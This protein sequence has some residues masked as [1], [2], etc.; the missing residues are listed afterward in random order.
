MAGALGILTLP[1]TAPSSPSADACVG[2]PLRQ[3]L[4]EFLQAAIRANCQAAWAGIAGVNSNVVERIEVNDPKDNTFVASKLPCLAIFRTERQRKFEQMGDDV[5][6]RRSKI[7]VLWIPPVAVQWHRA[8]REP[9]FQAV[10][11]AIDEAVVRGRTPTWVDTGD[12]ETRAA[13]EGSLIDSRLELLYPLA[14]D[15]QFDDFS[16]EITMPGA[17]P[18]K[19]P[20]LM[21]T[22]GIVE[23]GQITGTT[24]PNTGEATFVVNEDIDPPEYSPTQTYPE[25]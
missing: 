16:L 4:G 10:E 7:V 17:E 23:Q 1:V 9:F 15:M 3:K 21:A 18:K 6:V 11:A 25:P 24:N 8:N 13:T 12:T 14:L 19:Y 20:A 2:D 5:R 22:F